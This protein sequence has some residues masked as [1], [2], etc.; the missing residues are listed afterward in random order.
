MSKLNVMHLLSTNSFSG[1]ENVVFQIIKMLNQKEISFNYVSLN[2]PISS[3]CNESK[4]DFVPLENLDLNN[5]KKVVSKIK[6][7]IIHSHDI[8]AIFFSIFF[9]RRSKIIAHIHVNHKSMKYFSIRSLSLLLLTFFVSNIIW[10]SDS[11][12]NSYLFRFLIKKKSIILRNIIDKNTI[13]NKINLSTNDLKFDLVFI[14]RLTFQKNPEKL[15]EIINIIAKIKPDL[16]V[17]I[18]GDGDKSNQIKNLVSN[19]FLGPNINFF[20]FIDNPYPILSNSKVFIMTSRYEGTP[21]AALEAIALGIPIISTPVDGILNLV[22]HGKTGFL[23]KSNE[24]FAEKVLYLLSEKN[25]LVFVENTKNHFENISN[26]EF[27]INS[28]FKIYFNLK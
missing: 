10:V 23:V 18:I 5:L 14:G 22:L 24:E 17:A 1:A 6:P 16:K 3:K 21:M 19:L 13:I 8:K 27:F 4:I 28:L 2:G 26:K 15:I 20:G 25:R 12:Y 9:W 7:N 11:A